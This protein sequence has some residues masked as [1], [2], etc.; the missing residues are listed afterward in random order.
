MDP[1]PKAMLALNLL[2]WVRTSVEEQT[3]RTV[4]MGTS[5][6]ATASFWLWL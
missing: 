3:D 5:H 4:Q 1:I 2:H 6:T